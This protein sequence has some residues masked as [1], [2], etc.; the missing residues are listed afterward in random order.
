MIFLAGGKDFDTYQLRFDVYIDANSNHLFINVSSSGQPFTATV[1][2]DTVRTRGVA[3]HYSVPFVCFPGISQPDV[4]V[5]PIPAQFAPDTLVMY[6]RNDPTLDGSTIV[7]TLTQQGLASAIP[8]TPDWWS[9]LQ[10]GIAVDATATAPAQSTLKRLS[11][12]T[13]QTTTSAQSVAVRVTALSALTAS[14][15]VWLSELATAVPIPSPRAQ[16]EAWWSAFWARS[17]INVSCAPDS[18][19]PPPRATPLPARQPRPSTKAAPPVGGMSLWLDALSLSGTADNS[20]LALWPDQSAAHADVS[21]PSASLRPRYLAH[22]GLGGQPVVRFDG[23]SSFLSNSKAQFP[24]EKSIFAVMRDTGTTTICCSGVV[25]FVDSNN[26][27]GTVR[28]DGTNTA[29]NGD[30]DDTAPFR[31]ALMIDWAG[32]GNLGSQNVANETIVASVTYSATDSSSYASQCL[33][34]SEPGAHGAAGSGVQIGTR[35]NELAR[36]FMGDLSEVLVYPR[37]LNSSER[38]AVEAYLLAKWTT[39][40]HSCKQPHD[41][42]AIL[43]QQQVITRYVQTI[44]SRTMWPIKFNGMLFQAAVPP[45]ADY[46][47]WG[48]SN[49]WQN[50]RLSYGSMLQTGDVDVFETIL[51]YY[52]NTLPFNMA[53][54][55]AYFNHSGIFY[56]ETKHI[57]GAFAS[58]DYGCSRPQGWPVW[59]ET[60]D[61]I[62]ND[63]GGD[64]GTP[65]VALMV[66]DYFMYT[67][68]KAK[69]KQYLPIATLA[70][71][72]FRQHYPNRTNDGKIVVWP[73]Q[74]LE[75]Y[76]CAGWDIK[77]NRPPENCCAD[78][79]P[80]VAGM[81][82]LAEKLLKLPADVTTPA[83]RAQW[84]EFQSM[85]QPLPLTTDG[86]KYS[87]ARIVSSGVHNSET[88][89]LYGVHPYRL[90]TVGRHI[91]SGQDLTPAINSFLSDPLAHSN[92]G[93]NQGII[94]AALLGQTA[95]AAAMLG[96]RATTRSAPG[97]R[98]EGFMPH[99]QDYEPSSNHLANYLTAFNTMLLQPADDAYETGTMV[100]FPAWP[101]D[102]SVSFRL[103]GPLNT[104][105][106]V[107][108][109]GQTQ[110]KGQ[111]LQLIVDPPQRRSAVVIANCV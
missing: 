7:Q 50:T 10:Y 73:T 8:V 94:N 32:S 20:P 101:C 13:L 86:T 72:F 29:L 89:E 111:L 3:E 109:V 39:S 80:T 74:A 88:P 95:T 52:N 5:D 70:L 69:L 19:T 97:Y 92:E 56:T 16:H 91:V 90:T 6:H 21:Q 43:G 34:S 46:R 99:F 57:C 107:E 98:F 75:T 12:E 2:I 103:W 26:G 66:L 60:N 77:N 41:P 47:D 110:T 53:R 58:E 63:Y 25:H 42:C 68:D 64:G 22:G 36:F 93:W 100:L 1:N 28:V 78:D 14:P 79:L 31:V 96:Q 84:T 4:F 61:Y 37:A 49:W 102:W 9:Q 105:V 40:T 15:A 17:F 24:A 82:V 83:Q 71:D 27:L 23:V 51:K 55:Q 76:W 106:T 87:P 45:N 67:N 48:P 54:T 33:Q 44:Q 81:I 59:L 108:Y 38:Q 30:D 18:P 62:K 35:G 65:E 11:P 104:S 85:L